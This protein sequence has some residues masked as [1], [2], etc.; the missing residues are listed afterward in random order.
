MSVFTGE[1][2]DAPA[3]RFNYSSASAQDP[4]ARRGLKIYGPYD[5]G[6]FDKD[7]IRTAVIFPSDYTREKDTLVGGL[8]NGHNSFM[9]F[10]K[11]FR[12]PFSVERELPLRR[13]D[14]KEVQRAVQDL[15]R[16][17]DVDLALVIV[18]SQNEAVYRT[19]KQVLL[20]NGIPNQVATIR[21]L[22]DAQQ[23][24]WVLENVALACY[25]KIG[26]TPWVIASKDNRRELVIGI[27]RAQD[28]TKQIVVGFVTLFTQDGDFLLL[29]SL[30]PVLKWE[31][32]KYVSGLA[33]LIAVAY[34]EYCEI[35]GKPDAIILH[36]CK[37]PGRFREVE[38]IE[39][40]LR[41]INA[42]VPYA[43]IH[44]NDD[45]SYRLFDASYAPYY[46]PQA[47]L[48]VDLSRHNALLLLDGRI[49]DKR[50][51]RG[52]PRVLD[53][54]MD[55]RSTMPVDEFPRLVRQVYNF[56]RVNW[57]GFNASAVPVTL[58]YSY[59]IA[60]LIAEIG[61]NTWNQVISEG[62]LRDKAWFL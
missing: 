35:Q 26:G 5:S 32:E 25:A 54:S 33:K 42:S 27:S 4:D 43:L 15:A 50:Y 47:G 17:G 38:A 3:L 45:S 30:A 6:I 19:V 55:K 56:A 8:I 58:N 61:A 60:R 24:P 14:E 41:Q 20:G 2:L 39:Q 49:G 18:T 22:R 29:H 52:A 11:L 9:G 37:R 36:L 13:E 48:K 21:K 62:R 31:R 28:R 23:A 34:D 57:R 10:Q 44:L 53:I 59:L 1:L 12:I 46:I 40:A 16:Q 51:R 7:R